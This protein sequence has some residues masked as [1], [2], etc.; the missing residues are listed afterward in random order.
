MAQLRH[1]YARFQTLQADVLVV[2]PNGSKS[3]AKYKAE[4][5]PPYAILSDKGSRVAA[6]YVQIRGP[7]PGFPPTLFVV[8]NSGIIRYAYQAA[9]MIEEPS[10]EPA[11]EILARLF[12]E[13]P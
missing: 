12:E 11:L 10:N 7:I 2:V 6:Q 5:H 4:N 1:D 3:I 13:T 9:S 8:D